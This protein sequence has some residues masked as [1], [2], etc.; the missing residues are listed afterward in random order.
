MMIF[1]F[2]LLGSDIWLEPRMLELQVVVFQFPL[3][4]SF[5]IFYTP[6]FLH[7]LSIPSIGFVHLRKR[8]K[9]RWVSL[10]IP[11]IGFCDMEL[12]YLLNSIDFQFPLL[13]SS[14]VHLWWIQVFPQLSIPSIGFITPD[15]GVRVRKI[16]TF[17]SLYWVH[18]MVNKKM[19]KEEINFQFPLLGSL[20]RLSQHFDSS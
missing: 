16:V 20:D 2:P 7:E 4:G 13:G 8:W 19:R 17:N 11:S 18:L 15:A 12:R 14:Q 3:L 10:S 5:T 6:P 1:Q 9:Y